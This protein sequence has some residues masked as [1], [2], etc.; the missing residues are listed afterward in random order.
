M[1]EKPFIEFKQIKKNYGNVE[2]L[3][4]VDLDVNRGEIIGLVGDNAAGKSTFINI[5]SG[6]IPPTSGKVYFEGK[7]IK[8]TSPADARRLGI[9]T[10][11][12]TLELVDQLPIY[13]NIFLGR[14]IYKKILGFI[15]YLDVRAM[16]KK[17]SELINLTGIRFDSITRKVM[18]LSGGQR[19]IV[20]IA[21]AIF[22]KP[23]LLILDEPTSGIAAKGVENMEN[24]ILNLKKEGITTIYISHRIESIL[25]TA[26]R[27]IVLSSGVKVMDEK[28]ENLSYKDVVHKM[29]GLN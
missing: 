11:Y 8:L 10:V 16:I 28:N 7:E 2:A 26:D 1:A 25:K 24:I 27:I 6:T 15:P 12:Q 23:K 22:F 13:I 5:L 14:L 17:S 9:E 3:K 20:A 19:Q 21:R 4:G 18:E 29:F